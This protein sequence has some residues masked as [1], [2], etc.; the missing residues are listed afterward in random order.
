MFSSKISIVVPAYNESE[1]IEHN[2]L[3]C[4]D[5]LSNFGYDYEIIVVDDGSSDETHL[6]AFRACSSHPERIRII[7]YDENSGKGNALMCGS[8]YARGE[9]VVFLDADMELHPEQLP[10]FFEIM[11]A[12]KC[13][14]VIGS[15]YHPASNVQYPSNR[16][17]YSIGY[18]LLVKALF[19]LPLRDTQTGLKVFRRNLLSDVLPRLL[20]KRFAF[21]IELLVNAH[22]LGYTMSDAPVTLRFSRG[23]GRIKFKDIVDIALDTMAIFYRLR[24]A[25]YYQKKTGGRLQ[26]MQC[27]HASREL[28]SADAIQSEVFA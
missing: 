5:T 19:G 16:R 6:A 20:A 8:A 22:A 14:A 18:F 2:I 10:L 17:L 4:A 9:Y 1:R 23:F 11:A 27:V 12:K 21:D 13:D 28:I 25:R 15:K 3:D 24:I 7:R 26:S